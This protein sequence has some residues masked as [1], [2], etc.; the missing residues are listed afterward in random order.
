MFQKKPLGGASRDYTV[1][2]VKLAAPRVGQT[3]SFRTGRPALKLAK[4]K[5]RHFV[6]VW[7]M[8]LGK[9]SG[10]ASDGVAMI[11]AF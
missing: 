4:K 9:E 1:R 8:W 5:R 2:C 3:T 11:P 6:A 10:A 7:M